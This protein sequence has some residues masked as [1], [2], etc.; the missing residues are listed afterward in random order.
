MYSM[1]RTELCCSMMGVVLASR[2]HASALG[3]HHTKEMDLSLFES[4][5][6][7]YMYS[8]CIIV[9][10]LPTLCIVSSARRSRREGTAGDCSRLSV[11]KRNF[12]NRVID[13][14]S[15]DKHEIIT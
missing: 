12:I 4:L 14:L 7:M 10:L 2:C 9:Y 15:R 6:G 1:E 13:M 3:T 5:Y 8:A 11:C